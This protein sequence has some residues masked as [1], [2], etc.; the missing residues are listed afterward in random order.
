[1]FPVEL[2]FGSGEAL[3]GELATFAFGFRKLVRIAKATMESNR[4][5]GEK[6]S[7]KKPARNHRF[8]KP[9]EGGEQPCGI[10]QRFRQGLQR[11]GGEIL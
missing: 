3:E 7:C 10:V 2:I 9:P 4:I 11:P 1:V 8:G 6:S 5:P